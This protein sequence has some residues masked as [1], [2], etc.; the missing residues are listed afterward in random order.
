M[1]EGTTKMEP[2]KDVCHFVIVLKVLFQKWFPIQG[3]KPHER[4]KIE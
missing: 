4:K 2:K 3:A 1:I